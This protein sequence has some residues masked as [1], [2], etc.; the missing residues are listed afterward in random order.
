MSPTRFFVEFLA[1][2]GLFLAGYLWLIVGWA[3]LV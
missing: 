2:F 1:L 3:A